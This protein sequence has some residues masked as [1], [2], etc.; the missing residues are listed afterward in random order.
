M[1]R[2]DRV[3]CIFFLIVSVFIIAWEALPLLLLQIGMPQDV[4]VF[5]E[6]CLWLRLFV[7]AF[8]LL[9]SLYL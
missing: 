4:F 2:L 7:F 6:L 1:A 5:C 9:L 8:S 3:N